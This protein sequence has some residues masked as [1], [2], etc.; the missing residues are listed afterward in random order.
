MRVDRVRLDGFVGLNISDICGNGYDTPA[1]NHC[2]H[3]VSHAAGLSSGYTCKSHKGGARAGAAIRVLE[4]F[5]RCGQVG[6]WVDRP[7]ALDAGLIFVTAPAN[8]DIESKV[9][10]NHPKKHVGIFLKDVVW[11][12]S[13]SRDQVVTQSPEAFVQHYP[14]QTNSLYFG[15]F[16]P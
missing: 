4:L 15:S 2:A 9:M 13:N 11:H 8:V 16:P 14:R 5:A 12:Y 3:F 10:R 6:L 7:M 1:D